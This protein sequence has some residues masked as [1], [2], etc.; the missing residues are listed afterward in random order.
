M[1]KSEVQTDIEQLLKKIARTPPA[2]SKVD[3]Y[4]IVNDHNEQGAICRQF[5]ASETMLA[6]SES[7]MI[8]NN[9]VEQNLMSAVM[10]WRREYNE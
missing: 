5:Q 2:K 10:N 7:D 8:V 3:F 6:R 4:F 1:M 9:L